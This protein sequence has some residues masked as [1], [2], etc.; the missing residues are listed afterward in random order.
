G[1]LTG[2]QARPVR[3][4]VT[5]KGRSGRRRAR[6][7]REVY[8]DGEI[9]QP[10][11]PVGPLAPV[12]SAAP[13]RRRPPPPARGRRRPAR[14]DLRGGVLRGLRRPPDLGRSPARR[15]RPAGDHEPGA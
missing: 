6:A 12:R 10:Q 5:S 9:W 14:A 8:A 4:V 11:A 13:I 2:P 3:T 15:D 7:A 1:P